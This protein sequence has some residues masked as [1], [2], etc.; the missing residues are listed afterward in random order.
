M[1]QD[2]L[3][4]LAKD[5]WT[6]ITAGD[7]T[8]ITVV[9]RGGAEVLIQAT[10]GTAPTATDR[11]GFPIATSNNRFRDGFFQQTIT[12]LS[13]TASVDRVFAI[14]LGG[15]AMVYVQDDSV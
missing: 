4:S 1:A 14:A 13:P 7:S 12:E 2:A 3:I 6:E 9:H 10:T 5:T 8:I 11:K 15:P